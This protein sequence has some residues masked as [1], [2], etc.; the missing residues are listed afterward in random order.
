MFSTY[1]VPINVLK[2]GVEIGERFSRCPVVQSKSFVQNCLFDSSCVLEN[3]TEIFEQIGTGFVV[4]D[5]FHSQF[6]V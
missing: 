2:I 4:V 5:N 6:L 1:K 3:R